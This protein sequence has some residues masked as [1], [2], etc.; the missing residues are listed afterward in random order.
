MQPMSLHQ[1]E[2]LS[3]IYLLQ[4]G[5]EKS[6]RSSLNVKKKNKAE[7]IASKVFSNGPSPVQKHFTWTREINPASLE[8]APFGCMVFRVDDCFLSV[9]HFPAP[10]CRQTF[11]NTSECSATQTF[12]AVQSSLRAELGLSPRTFVLSL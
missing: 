8:N 7:P 5:G 11:R 6:D 12:R 1:K 2:A 10:S 3:C 4:W 9:R